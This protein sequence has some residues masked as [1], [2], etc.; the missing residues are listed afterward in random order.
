MIKAKKLE[1]AVLFS[2][3]YLTRAEDIFSGLEVLEK[4]ELLPV[5]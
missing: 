5:K 3:E 2:E 1:T 4:S